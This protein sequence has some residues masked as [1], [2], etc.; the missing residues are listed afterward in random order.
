MLADPSM[1]ASTLLAIME[2]LMTTEKTIEVDRKVFRVILDPSSVEQ[3]VFADKHSLTGARSKI[4]ISSFHIYG[5]EDEWF[6]P[7]R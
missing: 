5:D 4:F 6:W 2:K 3:K 1:I 7:R